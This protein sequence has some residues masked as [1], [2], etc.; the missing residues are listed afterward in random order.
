MKRRDILKVLAVSAAAAPFSNAAKHKERE[1]DKFQKYRAVSTDRFYESASPDEVFPKI[2][3]VGKKSKIE[4]T[5]PNLP[6]DIIVE[7]ASEDGFDLNGNPY[8]PE[9]AT[10]FK[11]GCVD[12]YG[13]Q[14]A[15]KMRE[16]QAIPFERKNGVIALNATFPREGRYVFSIRS[17][18][19][20]V[21][22][23]WVYALNPDLFALR[24]YRGDIHMHTTFSDGKDTNVEMAIVGLSKGYDFMSPSDHRHRE[25]STDLI[26]KFRNI[27]ASLKIFPAEEAHASLLHINNF[28][29]CG[30][31]EE[32]SKKERADF[33]ARTNRIL[34]TIPETLG[35]SKL[36]TLTLAQSEA[37]FE[38]IR[39]MGGLSVFNHPYWRRNGEQLDVSDALRDAL[40]SR[41]KFDAFELVNGVINYDSTD[42]SIVR[43]SEEA[44]NG[45]FM[46]VV[47]CTDA[48]KAA[49]L[50]TGITIAFAPTSELPD[51]KKAIM[52][53]NTVAMDT[54]CSYE[55]PKMYGKMRL[56]KYASF[57]WKNFFPLHDE[58]CL[59]QSEA[60]REFLSDGKSDNSR[61]KL[62][63]T[64][65]EL[66]SLYKKV[67]SE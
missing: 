47:G 9:Y 51:I 43:H 26:E 24:P 54:F 20:N 11:D 16:T 34:K 59:R 41:K 6:Q 65:K 55:R 31:I 3:E 15:A 12:G 18:R 29:S 5:L 49:E 19:K 40:I 13:K 10:V 46:P 1:L 4:I 57:L 8:F 48:H 64:V 2:F 45:R 50:G 23:V 44:A 25:G 21:G 61:S 37:V 35:L 42:L 27:P 58:I 67:W 52:S 62:E 17:G 38:K 30:S 22:R 14:S 33:D 63:N 32:W 7:C 28:G 39:E 56:M 53:L 66:N 36:D 60:L